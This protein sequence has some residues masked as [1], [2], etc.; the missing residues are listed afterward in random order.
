[1][2]IVYVHVFSIYMYIYILH[3]YSA[4]MSTK[5]R[6]IISRWVPFEFL[7]SA[8]LEKKTLNKHTFH[9]ATACKVPQTYWGTAGGGIQETPPPKSKSKPVTL[10]RLTQRLA[11]NRTWPY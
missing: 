5:R 2:S 6:I 1:M 3:H 4:K 7:E 9:N 8:H 11:E 10:G